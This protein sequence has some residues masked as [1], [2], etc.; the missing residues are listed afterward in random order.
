[1]SKKQF[2]FQHHSDVYSQIILLQIILRSDLDYY[3]YLNKE[4]EKNN[5]EKNSFCS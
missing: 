3:P 2:A 4:L 5:L 1:M